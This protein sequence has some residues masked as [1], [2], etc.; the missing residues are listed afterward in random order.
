ARVR[1]VVK[2]EKGRSWTMRAEKRSSSP[3]LQPFPEKNRKLF[4][5]TKC[6]FAQKSF[7]AT[8]PS[9]ARSLGTTSRDRDVRERVVVPKDSTICQT[10]SNRRPAARGYCCIPH[11]FP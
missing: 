1:R 6:C 7:Q 11:L 8:K 3:A 4:S 5:S 9:Q 2:R 10:P